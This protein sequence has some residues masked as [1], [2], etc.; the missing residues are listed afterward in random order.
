VIFSPDFSSVRKRRTEDNFLPIRTNE[1][2]ANRGSF[3]MDAYTHPF[4]VRP[5]NRRVVMRQRWQDLL[6]L[7]WKIPVETLQKLIPPDLEIDTFHGEA[8]IGL[9]PFT[10]RDVRPV[11]FPAFAPLS[12]FHEIN[13][14]TYVRH[15]GEKP[16][17]WFF[18]LD[19]ANRLAVGIAR[20]WFKLPYY[21]AK[22]SLER[23]QTEG[24][25]EVIRYSSERIQSSKSSE[26]SP[27]SAFSHVEYTPTGFPCPA[28]PDSLEAFLA[29]RYLLY[30]VA[31][32]SLFRGQVHHTPYPLQP[33]EIISLSD[34]LV[35]AAGVIVPDCPPIAHYAS[36]VNVEIFGLERV[37]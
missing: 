30:S 11:P 2:V 10:M 1:T 18:S 19:A 37:L 33:V 4:T 7:H 36:G 28:K 35:N 9:V 5:K 21:F 27:V 13:V 32:G 15:Q 8:F 20:T 25:A 29:E 31:N 17:V 16:G 23:Q 22:M 3:F 12:N 14:R 26:Q 6:F 34:S 24:K